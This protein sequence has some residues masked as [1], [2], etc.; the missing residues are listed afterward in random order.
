MRQRLGTTPSTCRRQGGHDV[1]GLA[2]SPGADASTFPSGPR[3]GP[4]PPCRPRPR[5]TGRYVSGSI[6]VALRTQPGP[7]PLIRVGDRSA[8]RPARA[9]GRLF[10]I[11]PRRGRALNSTP[12]GFS[13]SSSSCRRSPKY[14]RSW[15]R[16]LP[17]HS[18]RQWSTAASSSSRLSSGCSCLGGPRAINADRQA[19]GASSASVRSSCS[20]PGWTRTNNPPVNSRMLC[21]LSYR[22]SLSG[23]IVARRFRS[24][25]NSRIASRTSAS[26]C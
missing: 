15:L 18:L 17:G 1:C 8:G 6:H 13:S 23:A 22:G 4:C 25:A 2:G 11:R 7:E 19:S 5:G 10:S 20:S 9:G 26:R 21:Q 14:C 16:G 24:Y 12:C 3:C